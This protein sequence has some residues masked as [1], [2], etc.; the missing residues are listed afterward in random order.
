MQRIG[1]ESKQRLDDSLN[2]LII[3][4]SLPVSI[5]DNIYFQSFVLNLDPRY[6]LPTRYA[7]VQRLQ[8]KKDEMA[9]KLQTEISEASDCGITHDGWTSMNTESYFTTTIHYIDRNWNLQSAVLGTIKM[10]ESHT[11]ENI[12]NELKATQ[13]R[14]SFP[15]PIATTDNAANEQKA[16]E[17]LGWTRFGCYGHR[18]NLMVKHALSLPECSKILGKARKLVSFFHKS[19]SVTEMLTKKQMLLLDRKA[20]GHRLIIDVATRWN[21]SLEM[22]KRLL[23]QS[24]ALMALANDPS[25]SK[26]QLQQHSRTVFSHLKK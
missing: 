23:E 14:W 15:D 8:T 16:F 18:I 2:K 7:E 21:S 4:K 20:Q 10:P 26:K 1:P 11:S 25:L 3:G 19:S 12:A 9:I 13:S 17:I 24:P 22:L 6:K 5:V